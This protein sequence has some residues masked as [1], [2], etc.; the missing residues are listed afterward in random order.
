MLQPVLEFFLPPLLEEFG[1]VRD[2]TFQEFL[3]VLDA[4]VY[5]L[6]C[7]QNLLPFLGHLIYVLLSN[8]T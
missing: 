5:F 1:H 8:A 2:E 6:H 7:V 4:L 3:C